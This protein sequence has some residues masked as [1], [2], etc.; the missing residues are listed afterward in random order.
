MLSLPTITAPAAQAPK[1]C[2]VS[3]LFV[4]LRGS[5]E[6]AAG[7]SSEQ[8]FRWMDEFLSAM[9]S[10]VFR[11]GGTLDKFLGDGLLAY[12]GA[13]LP[14]PK[15]ATTAVECALDLQRALKALNEARATRGDPPLKI[16]I[17]IHTGFVTVGT[18]GPP[19][20]ARGMATANK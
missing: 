5:T 16:G 20:R 11:H 2:E 15:H 19:E 7:H 4:D 1:A 18:L 14:N 8:I 3:V 9:S 17:G 6:L 12:F 10:V 13:P